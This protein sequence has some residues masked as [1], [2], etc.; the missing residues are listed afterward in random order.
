MRCL[1][2]SFE[3]ERVWILFGMHFIEVFVLPAVHWIPKQL[4]VLF[5]GKLLSLLLLL[6][7]IL[8]VISH[9]FEWRGNDC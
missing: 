6:I 9:M 5:G 4:F 7:I 8:L 3:M 2:V 1:E